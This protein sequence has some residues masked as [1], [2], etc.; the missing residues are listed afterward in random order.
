MFANC[1][2]GLTGNRCSYKIQKS[3]WNLCSEWGIHMKKISFYLT[4]FLLLTGGGLLIQESTKDSKKVI[5]YESIEIV[6]G[7]TI[8]GIAQKYYCGQKGIDKYVQEIMEFN[9]MD[10]S[11]IKSGQKIIVPIKK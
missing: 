10:S 6:K 4:L 3:I 11:N 7:D 2:K 1:E 8:W 5:Y 9:H